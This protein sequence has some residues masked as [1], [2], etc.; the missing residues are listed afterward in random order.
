MIA[1]LPTLDC[2][3]PTEIFADVLNLGAAHVIECGM[4]HTASDSVVWHPD[5]RV[6]FAADLI[7]VD[8][9]LN[10][11]H[12]DPQSW[13]AI[14]DRLEALDPAHVVPGHGPPAGPEAIAIARDYIETLLDLAARAGEHEP[15]GEYTGW[16]FPEGFQ[17][18]LTAL[19]AR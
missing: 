19:R 2:T 4:G 6:L 11:A 7:G 3:P 5:G 1:E 10:L 8:S 16:A 15:P 9:H 17:Q 18:N 12:G 14:L 13:L